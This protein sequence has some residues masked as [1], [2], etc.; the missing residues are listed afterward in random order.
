MS[1][2]RGRPRKEG[3][4][5]TDRRKPGKILE[6]QDEAKVPPMPDP[7][8]WI[9]VPQSP[10]EEGE[11]DFE[12]QW[13]KPVVKWWNDIWTSPMSQE[14]VESDIHGLYMACV[15]FHESLNPYYKVAERLKN[16]QAWETTIAKYGLTPTARESLRWQVAQGT[17]AQNRTNQIRSQQKAETRAQAAKKANPQGNVID[18]YNNFG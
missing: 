12:P 14:F 15:Y 1:V 6:N 4:T 5:R 7:E 18:L 10:A 17:Q 16:A 8:D 3:A 2:G 9:Q 11:V 13:A